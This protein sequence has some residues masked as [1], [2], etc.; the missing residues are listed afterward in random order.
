MSE[1]LGSAELELG[2]DLAP[3]DAGLVKAEKKV[4]EAMAVMQKML[5]RHLNVQS[6]KLGAL[7]AGLDSEIAQ[8]L[9]ALGGAFDGAGARAAASYAEMRVGQEAVAAAIDHT[10]E[11]AVAASAIEVAAADRVT[12]AYLEQAAT[13]RAAAE[14]GDA[15]VGRALGADALGLAGRGAAGSSGRGG[16]LSATE[17]AALEGVRGKGHVGGRSNPLV[18]VVEAARYT[19]LGSLGAAIAENGVSGT[20]ASSSSVAGPAAADV[21]AATRERSAPKTVAG[22]GATDDRNRAVQDAALAAATERLAAAMESGVQGRSGGGGGKAVPVVVTD[23]DPR[24]AATTG[25]AVAAALAAKDFDK[26]LGAGALGVPGLGPRSGRQALGPDATALLLADEL[27]KVASKA[28]SGSSGGGGSRVGTLAVTRAV[29][30]AMES[31]AHTRGGGG[32]AFGS[33]LGTAAGSGGGGG[34]VP[35]WLMGLLWGSHAG[36]GGGGGGRPP[37]WLGY[38]ASTGTGLGAG[39]GSLGSFAGF[40]PEHIILTGGGIAGS[41]VAALGGGALLGAG[42]AGKLAVGGGSD[43]AV[44]SSTI[45][46]TKSLY[47]AYENVAKA[48]RV[49]GK[50]SEQA[51][52]AQAELNS[53]FVEL[54][55]TAGM[56]AEQGVAQAA[57][58]LNKLW[59]Q[60]TSGARVQASKVLMMGI[61]LGKAYVPLIAHAAEQNISLQAKGLKPLF[62]WL[63]GPEGMG[64]FLMLEQEFKEEIPEAMAALNQGVQFFGKTIAYVAPET[65]G[66]LAKL[67]SFFTKWNSPGEFGVW[68]NEMDKLIQD[69]RVWDAFVK[70]LGGSL[71]DLF[72]RDSHTGEGIIEE[73]TVML[74]KVREWEK[75]TEG[76]NQIH[77]LFTVHKEEVLELLE[78]LPPLISSF[79]KIYLTV[80]PPLVKAVTDVVNVFAKLLNTI[81]QAG[82]LAEWALGLTVIAGKLK[83]LTPLLALLREELKGTAAAETEAAGGATAFAGAETEVAGASAGSAGVAATDRYAPYVTPYGVTRAPGLGDRASVPGLGPSGATAEEQLGAGG[84]AA[85]EGGALGLSAAEL[86]GLAL[87]GGLGGFLGLM[88]GSLAAGATGAHG[89]LGTA[90][91]A[92][93][94]GA[95]LG[96]TLGPAAGALLGTELA[97]GIGTAIGAGL[98]FAAPY[99]VKFLGEVFSSHAPDYGKKFAQG[100]VA[101]FGA[102][103]APEAAQ[104]YAKAIDKAANEAHPKIQLAAE[105][106]KYQHATGASNAEIA[107]LKREAEEAEG[108]VG[109][110]AARAF[111]AAQQRVRFPTRSVLLTS[112][113][114]SLQRLPAA[115]QGA[116]AKAMLAYATELE[117][118]GE[119]AKGSVANMIH[120]L[121]GLFPG[122]TSYLA[123]QGQNTASS[124]AK[125]FELR[126]ARAKLADTLDNISQQF[127]TSNADTLNNAVNTMDALAQ[128]VAHSKGPLHAAAAEAYGSLKETVLRQLELTKGGAGNLVE[129]MNA[130]VA[131][132]MESLATGIS[133]INKELES[134]L[135]TLGA[136]KEVKSALV[137]G[138]KGVNL[139]ESPVPNNFGA[140]Q[141]ALLQ[142]GQEG[143][144]GHDSVP[145]NVGGMPIVVAPGEQVA[146]FT[147]QQQAVANAA[148]GGIGGLPGLFSTYNTPHYM[149]SGGIATPKVGGSG[150]IGAIVRAAVNDVDRA[151]NRKLGKAQA[152]AHA[153]STAGA[154]PATVGASSSPA[155]EALG[156]RMMIA[157]GFSASEWPYLQKLWEKESGWSSTAVNASS[158]AAGIAQSLG[159]GPVTLGDAAGQIAW[160]LSYIQGRY[161]SPAGAWAHEVANNWYHRGGLLGAGFARGGFAKGGTVTHKKPASGRPK[162]GKKLPKIAHLGALNPFGHIPSLKQLPEPYQSSLASLNSTMEHTLPQ[163]E[164]EYSLS[165]EQDTQQLAGA[166]HG[167]EFI[168]T[169][170]GIEKL[171]G[172]TLPWEDTGNVQLRLGQLNGLLGF[173]KRIKENLENALG[174]SG[175]VTAGTIA[176]IKERK[177]AIEEIRAKIKKLKEELAAKLKKIRDHIKANLG[178]M[179]TLE[180]Q[181]EHEGT[182][183]GHESKVKA[184]K[185]QIAALKKDNK[186]LGGDETEV[187]TGGQIGAATNSTDSQVKKLQG[188]ANTLQSQQKELEERHKMISSDV[189]GIVGVSG[190]GGSLAQTKLKVNELNQQITEVGG[191]PQK[192]KEAVIEAGGSGETPLELAERQKVQ[193]EEKLKIKSEELL[194]S[195]R[196]VSAFGGPGDIGIG[197]VNAFTAAAARGGLFPGLNIL[198]FGGSFAAGGVVPGPIGAPVGVVAHGGE[199]Y[200]GVGGQRQP[201]VVQ[202]WEINTLHPGDPATLT[203]IGKAATRGIGYQGLRQ[204]KRWTPGV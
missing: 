124:F 49:Y 132:G 96:F 51:I 126:E 62:D 92:G 90:I 183:K 48:I 190:H 146:V 179:A 84:E 78:V 1:S 63:K 34:G 189:S 24:S 109:E 56:K 110:A 107:K 123:S 26:P 28:P 196:A 165:S 171:A 170:S 20:P 125:V 139:R 54:G 141:G 82:P 104:S 156:K 7:A 175:T 45:A 128:V 29:I 144:R 133:T 98:G 173:Q 136:P 46:D 130:R 97:P 103:M 166:P 184:L 4:A 111:I 74:D 182:G 138:K 168:I 100:F 3:L 79:S 55:N 158:G 176:A 127:G 101:P 193:L 102:E 80:A 148:L 140:A 32:S 31:P 116:A 57:K 77:N 122:L 143:Q 41:G 40:G 88:G 10:A 37:G 131:L 47:A 153:A 12:A 192:L 201:S 93:G 69:F 112:M 30:S 134:E 16:G 86:K 75:S 118:K 159:H 163:L 152:K 18:V 87:R 33:A 23:T 76:G 65:G 147:H 66:F 94:A 115:A 6:D 164:E 135:G 195:N 137:T 197:G 121:E 19:S 89:T 5:D 185:S 106:A 53:L 157:A 162:K 73:L 172:V 9:G 13:A 199:E 129:E 120:G 154:G 50:D 91:S 14:A 59:D 161:G 155:N 21:A 181:V 36:G 169:P 174:I 43:A 167:G 35:P 200:M 11:V 180:K 67:D 8:R 83:V 72:D 71:V 178:Q 27:E 151:A 177:K 61:E 187:G 17:L 113:E 198:P 52:V 58:G 160:G 108:K 203:A 186:T 68:E 60:S 64:I 114:E 99:A 15:A 95:G 42:A 117:H 25:D 39:F 22:A 142:V 85:A 149:A 145:L 119:L 105:A 194:I 188:N 81:D 204:S 191:T 38:L 150:A 44:M 70:A 202:H 2:I